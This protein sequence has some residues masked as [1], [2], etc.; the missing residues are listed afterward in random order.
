MCTG[1]GRANGS[2]YACSAA[3]DNENVILV[4]H[5][6]FFTRRFF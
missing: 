5:N 1:F 6:H 3:T 4:F 2:P